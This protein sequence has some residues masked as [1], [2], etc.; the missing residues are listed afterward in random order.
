[1]PAAERVL[2][3]GGGIAGLTLARALAQRHV[4]AELV[5]RSTT[6]EVVGAGLSVQPNGMRA[7]RRLGLE[8]AVAGA[9]RVLEEW[10]FADEQGDTLCAVDLASVW[11]DVGPFVGITRRRLQD[12]LVDGARGVDCRLGTTVVDI[13]N[14]ADRATVRFSD[15]S[16]D[17][18][19]LVVGAD[20]I[21]SSVRALALGDIQ[22]QYAGQMSWRSVSPIELAGPP[23]VQ[24]WLGDQC[25]FGLCWVGDG[26]TYG[27]GSTSQDRE[28][29]PVEG[30]LARL[31]DR[32]CDFGGLVQQY[33]ASLET[34]EQIHCS[35]IEWLEQDRWWNGRVAL[36]GDAAHASSPMMGQ[37]GCLAM[38]DACVLADLIASS[39]RLDDALRSWVERRAPRV[40]WV[41][42][43]SRAVANS[44]TLD[45]AARNAALRRGGTEMFRARYAP[46]VPDI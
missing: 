32:F 31:R 1:M 45:P 26:A 4:T 34:D 36:I 41:Q 39:D 42:Q 44:F 14:D 13:A 28:Y 6:W 35:S 19:D 8:D 23:S 2:I 16:V 46:L 9:G 40:H 24:F 37:G 29:D 18:F 20:G 7:L 27:F 22:P 38:E 43:Q 10:I 15:G 11:G 30:R 21:A 17:H 12:A 5:E 3:V 33:L 25:F